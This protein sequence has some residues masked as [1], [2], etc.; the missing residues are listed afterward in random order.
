MIREA[1]NDDIPRL[2][3]M[4]AAFWSSS[5]WSVSGPFSPE[6]AAP[7]FER[8]IASPSVGLF[9]IDRDGVCGA[10]AVIISDLWCVRGG[11]LAQEAFWWVEPQGSSEAMTL[12]DAGE[13]FAKANGAQ[14]LAMIR[15]EGM[16]DHAVDGLYRRR[17]YEVR[18]HLYLRTL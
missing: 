13:R 5:P 14:A 12:W 16:R 2:V 1:V 11:V 8:F 15:L 10:I 18:E 9:V 3:E 17:G 7:A 6:K 4:G